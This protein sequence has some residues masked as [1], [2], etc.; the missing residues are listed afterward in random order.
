MPAFTNPRT[1]NV[2]DYT[3]FLRE[4]G[5]SEADLPDDSFWISTTLDIG[6]ATANL[7]IALAAPYYVLA[8]YN[9]GA[10]RLLNFATDQPD[11]VYFATQRK[12]LGLLSYAAGVVGSS[13]GDGASQS[14]EVIEAA[15]AFTV[16]DVQ[17]MKTPFGRNYIGIAQTY[18]PTIWGLT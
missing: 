16:T 9:F 6:K 2:T 14:L 1:P 5:I 10:D 11:R 4:S 18:G 3:A 8:V 17:L 15:K 12:N 13:S 7:L